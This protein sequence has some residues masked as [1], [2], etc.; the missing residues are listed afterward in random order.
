MQTRAIL[1]VVLAG[2][3]A[4]SP[5]AI[6]WEQDGIPLPA[7]RFSTTLQGSEAECVNPAN[8]NPESCSTK[9]VL[10]VPLSVLENGALTRDSTGNA[11]G[12][13]TAIFTALPVNASPPTVLANLHVTI[14]V[15]NYDP[16]TGTGDESFTVYI[17]G[18]CDGATFKSAGATKIASGASHFVVTHEGNRIDGAFTAL[19][20]APGLIAFGAFSVS[21]TQLRQ[22]N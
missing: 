15:L 10:V 19:T 21:E 2:A 12:A 5:K 7:G 9:G 16:K 18:A 22:T 13:L 20:G 6:A 17:G 8:G 3:L 4:A 14:K 1:W 11:C